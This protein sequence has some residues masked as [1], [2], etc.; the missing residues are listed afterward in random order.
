MSS[1]PNTSC[2]PPKLEQFLDER[3]ALT[4]VHCGLCLAACPTYLETGNENHSPRGRIYLMRQIQNGR[5][6][7]DALAVGPID[8]C[9]GCLACQPA[10]PAGVPYG[11]LL[12]TT[13]DFIE[14]HHARPLWE[15]LLR[16][17]FIHQVFPYPWR[18]RL[19][20]APV[21]YLRHL[22][23]EKFLPQFARN[24]LSL[25]P[26]EIAE[27]E[28]LPEF[29]ASTGPRR[30][31]VGFVTGCVQS[32]LFGATNQ[33]SAR[34]LNRA[35]YD[36]VTPFAQGCCGAIFSHSG[37]LEKARDC[38][39]RN[40]AAFEAED[41]DYIVIT[42]S[43]CGSTLKAYG[44]LL[45]NDP[46]W[47]ARAEAFSA[48]VR[49]LVELL[50]VEMLQPLA[51][52][53][54]PPV[55]YHDACHLA[56]PQGIRQQ[57]RDLLKAV[58][59]KSY[60]ELPETELCCGS[61]GTYNLTQPVMAARLQQRKIANIIQTGAK[62]VVTTKPGCLLQIQAGLRQAGRADIEALHLADFLDRQFADRD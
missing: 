54:L 13:R 46:K 60:V 57:P 28:A 2:R 14:H 52:N 4:C 45:K 16:R 59:G 17:V 62:L 11:E 36:V 55:T 10:C 19:A 39:R 37:H 1:T 32:V 22:G 9:L 49:D 6:P 27:S 26:S 20:T 42:A 15:L 56:N 61:A 48:K 7:L 23:I 43:G 47:A 30:G 34:L 31:R 33:A 35:G 21:K 50:P 38:A 24:A 5:A 3:S 29:S 40:I 41:L 44:P 8:L 18:M 58:C 12:E 51:T 25:L 53:D